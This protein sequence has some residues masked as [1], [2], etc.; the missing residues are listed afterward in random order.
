[1]QGKNSYGKAGYQICPPPG[2]AETYIFALYALPTA[3][4]PK[5]GFD[6]AALRS[7]A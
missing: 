2:Q 1:M 4:S 6:P 5:Q 3:L 7:Q